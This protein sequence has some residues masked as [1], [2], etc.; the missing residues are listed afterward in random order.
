M[1]DVFGE[2]DFVLRWLYILLVDLVFDSIKFVGRVEV[3]WCFGGVDLVVH[4]LVFVFSIMKWI[5]DLSKR[6]MEC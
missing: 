3:G 4:V 1:E 2:C 6:F 5:F